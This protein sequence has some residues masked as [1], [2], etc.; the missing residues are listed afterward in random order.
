[1]MMSRICNLSGGTFGSVDYGVLRTV[2][3]N[4]PGPDQAD[5]ILL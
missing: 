2:D 1:M 4:N 5:S 3:F